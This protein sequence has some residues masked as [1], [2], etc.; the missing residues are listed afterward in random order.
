MTGTGTITWQAADPESDPLTIS[1]YA[2]HAGGAWEEIAS[3]LANSGSYSWNTTSMANSPFE[4]IRVRC[5]DGQG[6]SEDTSAIFRVWNQHTIAA[7]IAV[8]R[9]GGKGTPLIQPVIVASRQMMNHTYRVTFDDTSSSHLTYSVR[10]LQTSAEVVHGATE[11]DGMTEG[12]LFDGLRL[13]VRNFQQVIVNEDSTGWMTGG[14]T[15]EPLISLPQ[16]Q[17][18][19]RN[20]VG[21]PYPADYQVTVSDHV[22]DTSAAL[23]GAAAVPVK[24]RVWNTTDDRKSEFVFIDPDQDQSISMLDAIIIIERD[25]E[26]NAEVT[27]SMDFVAVANPLNPANGDIFRLSTYKPATS[28]DV[29]EFTPMATGIS[30]NAPVPDKFIL[31]QNYPNPFNP[32]TIIGFSTPSR[33]SV[34]LVIFDILGRRVRTLINQEMPPG[35]H[36]ADWDATDDAGQRVTSGVYFVRLNAGSSTAVRKMVLVR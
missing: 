17:Y 22:V 24:F 4:R 20:I 10:D 6:Y 21:V 1:L 34:K 5:S 23:F 19:G 33:S 3:G 30:G 11:L 29:F 2:Q 26:G 9:R 28:A 35:S 25:G 18:D 31:N 14:S 12:P 13:L 32:G 8:T 16:F 7:G 36:S 27:W 15:L